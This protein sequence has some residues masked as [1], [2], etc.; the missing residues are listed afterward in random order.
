M[1]SLVFTLALC[2]AMYAQ[3]TSPPPAQ[4]PDTKQVASTPGATSQ[5]KS[6]QP[7][8][9]SV[10]KKA[11]APETWSQ[12][13][14]VVSQWALVVLAIVGAW[15][16]YHTVIATKKSADAAKKSADALMLGDRAWVLIDRIQDPYLP[17]D[18]QL[19]VEQRMANCVLFFR[20][21]GKTP[22]KITA[23]RFELKI[24]DNP[25]LPP[26]SP[27]YNSPESFNPYMLS[28]DGPTA[29]EA[30]MRSAQRMTQECA[31]VIDG[32]RSLWLCGIIKYVDVFERGPDSEHETRVCYVWERMNTPAPFWSM[33]GDANYNKFT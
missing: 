30:R 4:P 25:N 24:S 1:R 19:N 18:E 3:V 21:F 12:W 11:F 6:I 2:A 33:R 13:A 22:A 26:T 31:S 8:S 10:V 14:L 27:V 29:F 5:S 16:A 20:N 23:G 9:Q 17:T 15:F 7:E 32:L 28:P